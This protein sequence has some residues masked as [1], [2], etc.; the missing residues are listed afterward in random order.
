[1]NATN[2]IKFAHEIKVTIYIA[3]KPT[4]TLSSKKT[5]YLTAKIEK[6]SH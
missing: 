2:V 5:G 6:N 4:Y 1:M 3:S